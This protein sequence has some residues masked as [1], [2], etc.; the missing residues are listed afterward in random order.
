MADAIVY[1][2][3]KSTPP[4]ERKAA[5]MEALCAAAQDC[6]LGRS[7]LEAYLDQRVRRMIREQNTQFAKELSQRSLERPLRLF[8]KRSFSRD[9]KNQA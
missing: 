7:D 1:Q 3:G 8:V 4:A 6:N 2:L 9:G 5:A